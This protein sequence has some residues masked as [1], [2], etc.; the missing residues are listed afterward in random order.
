MKFNQPSGLA[1]MTQST[2]TMWM[3]SLTI[4]VSGCATPLG[5]SRASSAVPPTAPSPSTAPTLTAEQAGVVRVRRAPTA[6]VTA[7][8]AT[9]REGAI[10]QVSHSENASGVIHEGGFPICYPTGTPNCPPGSIVQCPPEPRFPVAG[11]VPW[12]IGMPTC[13]AACQPSPFHYPD[14]YLCDGGDRDFP[15][16][17]QQDERHGL[18]TE[19]TL[20]EFTDHTGRQRT[21]KSNRVCVYAPRFSAVRTVSLP[22]EEGSFQEVAGM[23]HS[24][25]GGEFRTRLAPNQGNKNTALAGVQMRSRASGLLG[26]TAKD[27][28]SQR[29]KPQL[30]DKVLNTFQDLGL[31]RIG[32]IEQGDLAQINLGIRSAMQWS[33][34]QYPIIQG[35]VDVAVTGLVDVHSAVITH[36]D[37]KD[38]DKPGE[39][40]IVK[41]ADKQT[42]EI[43]DVI[44][45]TLRY[46]NLGPREVHH[47]RVVD[48]LTPRLEYVAD[49]A[50]SQ[51]DGRLVVQDNGEG[52]QVLVWELTEP[53]APKTGGVVTFQA[54]VR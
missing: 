12:G 20:A 6:P 8:P 22:H 31:F 29:Q 15:V 10:Q 41:V 36:I 34:E 33:R 28:V 37:D 1:L 35:K 30:A 4:A 48:N 5:M 49:S 25:Q 54:K 50:T 2:T 46:D 43:G 11:P 32:T 13:D 7:T 23:G 26:E 47:V 24:N 45:F 39:L 38:S 40:R 27:D 9:P 19:D 44:T 16:H 17:Y 52:S 42:A 3:L 51:R 18:D 53:L 14:E 21:S